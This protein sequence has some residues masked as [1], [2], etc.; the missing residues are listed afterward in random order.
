MPVDALLLGT[1]LVKDIPRLEAA[2]NDRQGVTA[3]FNRNM[4]SVLNR[5]LGANFELERFE[6]IARY[7]ARQGWIE[8]LL[9]STVAQRVDRSRPRW[10]WTSARASC[11]APR[12]APSSPG[13]G[14]GGDSRPRDA[15]GPGPTA[16]GTS[17]SPWPSRPG[18]EAQSGRPRRRAPARL[19]GG[20]HRVEL[21]GVA[22]RRDA[23]SSVSSPS[24]VAERSASGPALRRPALRGRSARR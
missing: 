16:G 11:C 20:L 15:P 18:L 3:E 7:D 13:A 1:D 4:L 6:H 24:A 23:H 19:T 22:P 21:L 12:S 5:E 8:M 9:R 14:E 17:A 10:T 2:Y